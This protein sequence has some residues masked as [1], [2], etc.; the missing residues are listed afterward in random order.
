M[1]NSFKIYLIKFKGCDTLCPLNKFYEL[2]KD[3]LVSD[4]DLACKQKPT[5]A[6]GTI[7]FYVSSFFSWILSL[8]S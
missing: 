2:L 3:N 8:L 7:G 6:S 5:I 4:I 1:T